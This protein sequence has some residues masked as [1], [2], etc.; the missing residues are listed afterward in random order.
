[1]RLSNA[2]IIWI[3]I[4]CSVLVI[5]SMLFFASKKTEQK[6]EHAPEVVEVP[7]FTLPDASG[8]LHTLGDIH[9]EIKII[10]FWASWSPYSKSELTLLGRI[11]DEFGGSVFVVALN[12]D[13]HT[14]DGVSFLANEDIK[15]DILF[16]FDKED[17]YFRKVEGYAVPETII[18]NKEDQ[19]L[20]RKRGPITYEE[21]KEFLN[22][23]KFAGP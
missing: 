20:F 7:Q 2:H 22:E 21:I 16:V 9:A 6:Q 23:V 19:V 4:T 17:E 5:A 11:R 8:E 12:R 1:M 15:G 3:T 14:Q 13:M 18:L 10:N